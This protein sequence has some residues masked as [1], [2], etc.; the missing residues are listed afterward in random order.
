[1]HNDIP[2]IHQHPITGI[3][4]FHT[5]RHVTEFFGVFHHVIGDGFHMAIR[6]AAGDDQGIRH[7]GHLAHI[8]LHNIFSFQIFERIDHDLA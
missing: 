2:E 4:A 5:E 3:N 1:M 6:G 7:I 8:Q